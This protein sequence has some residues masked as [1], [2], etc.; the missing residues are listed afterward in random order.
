MPIRMVR[1]AL[2]DKVNGFDRAE[3]VPRFVCDVCG[4]W[5]DD[6]LEGNAAWLAP[7]DPTAETKDCEVHFVH[8]GACDAQLQSRLEAPGWI[9]LWEDLLDFPLQ[10][11]NMST[12]LGRHPEFG[13]LVVRT[14]AHPR[15]S[16]AIDGERGR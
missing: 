12:P 9:C 14:P 16:A 7:V 2:R 5:I 13:A 4:R 11:A 1:S 8:K 15:Y 6:A 3:W 10:L